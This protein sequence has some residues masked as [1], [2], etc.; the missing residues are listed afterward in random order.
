MYDRQIRLWGAEAQK[1]LKESNVLIIG[2]SAVQAEVAK[3]LVLS[4]I[5]VTLLDDE[6][7]TAEDLGANFFLREEHIGKPVRARARIYFGKTCDRCVC[8][9]ARALAC[10]LDLLEISFFHIL[11][12]KLINYLAVRIAT[13][14]PDGCSVFPQL[15]CF[16]RISRYLN[17]SLMK[18]FNVCVRMCSLVAV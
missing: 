10:V 15:Q 4:G 16:L 17:G 12:L 5:S 13:W 6:L 11:R 3:N 9:Y 2:L 7:V 18:L 14:M 8:V 1:R